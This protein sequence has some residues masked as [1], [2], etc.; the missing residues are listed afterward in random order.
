MNTKGKSDPE[1][2]DKFKLYIGSGQSES[3]GTMVKQINAGKLS[4]GSFVL[5]L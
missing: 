2:V 3:F 5:R 4:V 1:S